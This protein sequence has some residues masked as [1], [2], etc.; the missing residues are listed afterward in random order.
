VLRSEGH[1]RTKLAVAERARISVC[2]ATNVGASVHSSLKRRAVAICKRQGV[3]MRA[4]L[5]VGLEMAVEHFETLD[6]EG[7]SDGD[8]VG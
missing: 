4:F 1:W 3:T 7:Q 8:S 6:Q 5:S 2:R